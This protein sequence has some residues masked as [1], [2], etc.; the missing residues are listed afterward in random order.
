MDKSRKFSH[1]IFGVLLPLLAL[2]ALNGCATLDEALG[3]AK[4]SPDESQVITHEPL[5]KPEVVSLRPPGDGV[6]N[7]IVPEPE[8]L[9]EK[10]RAEIEAEKKRDGIPLGATPETVAVLKARKAEASDSTPV[11]PS[12]QNNQN[13]GSSEQKSSDDKPWWKIW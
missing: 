11:A 7:T 13:Q 3:L 9:Q 1:R 2:F 4:I 8:D 5:V 10:I 12:I 6:D